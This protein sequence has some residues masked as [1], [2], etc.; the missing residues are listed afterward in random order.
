MW[1]SSIVGFGSYHYT[2]A[3]GRQADWLLT[4]F[5]PRKQNITLYIMDGFA[6]YDALLT[7]LGKHACGKS[8]LYIKGLSDVHQPTLK[9]L[10]RSSVRYLQTARAHAAHPARRRHRTRSS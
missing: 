1:G 4:G 9:K 10:V 3:S 5:S 6:N 2:Y 8:C 7:R